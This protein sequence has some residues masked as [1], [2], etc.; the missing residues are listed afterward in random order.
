MGNIKA[1]LQAEDGQGEG[2]AQDTAS[3][4]EAPQGDGLETIL[5]RS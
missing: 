2:R 3:R 5:T 1:D 4:W